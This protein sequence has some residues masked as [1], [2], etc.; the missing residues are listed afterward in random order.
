MKGT[1]GPPM[2]NS[3]KSTPHYNKDWI[4]FN[5]IQKVD[6]REI[7]DNNRNENVG[8]ENEKESE[9]FKVPNSNQNLNICEG[10]N[11]SFDPENSEEGVQSNQ[12]NNEIEFAIEARKVKT[13]GCIWPLHLYQIFTWVLGGLEIFYMFGEVF[14]YMKH[15]AMFVIF[16][17]IFC[18]LLFALIALDTMLC[19]SDPTDPVVYE[20]RIKCQQEVNG[21]NHEIS[22]DQI[23]PKISK[24]KKIDTRDYANSDFVYVCDICLT[25]VQDKTKHWREWNRCVSGFD[26]HWKWL[27][28]W[29]GD[30]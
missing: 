28:N 19:F 14:P 21:E 27:N 25:H 15:I 24:F 22:N 2:H 13:H 30:K 29:I 5:E 20:E 18:F 7:T 3:N 8:I 10:R 17:L 26:H 16:L 11:D 4:I 23:I 6:F 1:L 9:E 12:V